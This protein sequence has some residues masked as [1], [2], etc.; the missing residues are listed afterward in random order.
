[1]S[2]K[3]PLL[4]FKTC[5]LVYTELCTSGTVCGWECINTALLIP[6]SLLQFVTDKNL[7]LYYISELDCKWLSELS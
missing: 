3:T 6:D 1:M 4:S 7:V 2:F 5:S